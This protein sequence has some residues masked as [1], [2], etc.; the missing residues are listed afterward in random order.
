MKPTLKPRLLNS[1][2]GGAALAVPVLVAGIIVALFLGHAAERVYI[3]FLIGL[4]SVV[5]MG[6]YI[7][8]SGIMSFGHL[9]FMALGAYISGILTLSVNLKKMSLP[10]L[11]EFLKN[12]EM[13]LMPSILISIL[14]VIGFAWVSG[15]MLSRLEGSAASIA[16]L[17]LLVIVHGIII[18][19]REITR[20]SQSF[21]GVPQYTSI[22][23][24]IF[25]AAGT[26]L[27]ARIFRDSL[28]GLQL[29]ASRDDIIAAESIGIDA[30]KRR[31]Q[32]WVLS[33]VMVSLAGILIGHFLGTFSPKKF[34]FVDTF[35]L[36]AMLIIGGKESVSGAI[37]GTILITITSE[38]LRHF[39]TGVVLFG[40]QT[41]AIFGTTQIG[42]G[43]IILFVMYFRPDGL[44]GRFEIDRFIRK[45][46]PS[47]KTS[48]K[49]HPLNADSGRQD[50]D[51]PLSAREIVMNFSGLKAVDQVSIDLRPGEI[52]GLIGPNGSGKTTL[53][54]ILSGTLK[55][56]KGNVY[57]GD[58]QITHLKAHEIARL[59]IA[60]TFQNIRLFSGLTVREHIEL[61]ALSTG[62][63][64]NE[65][66]REW[67][68]SLLSFMELTIYENRLAVELSY[69]L[70]RKVEIA[71][72]LALN[73]RYL[74]LDEPA[75]GLNSDE[76]TQLM[77]D[78]LK[79]RDYLGIGLLIVDH[80]MDMMMALCTR[81]VVL[82]EGHLLAQ[83]L[84]EE[85]KTDP[86]VIEAYMGKK[87][88][89]AHA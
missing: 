54:N 27:I 29:R 55:C 20:G 7:G 48:Q 43:L 85:V 64:D 34:Y 18:A 1:L 69:G 45:K 74:L 72:A 76:S 50:M 22:G 15:K 14:I 81:M 24:C 3:F 12:I 82:N 62:T 44:L 84:P 16:T 42:I 66:T 5:G 61:A 30:K 41:P 89:A 68:D 8:N 63:P 88:A 9:S 2:I 87:Y 39:E 47:R 26:I 73:P 59:N 6:V 40:F 57:I 60:R 11:P 25:F 56:T 71:R 77:N 32:A 4:M 78:L 83:G 38:L 52:V 86:G 51:D 23:L 13:S 33:A 17:G 79:L 37:F 67:I 46:T 21:F 35:A 65:S 19:A 80:D 36:L 28:P 58:Q 10:M 49:F 53:L 70:Q 31:L 75:A